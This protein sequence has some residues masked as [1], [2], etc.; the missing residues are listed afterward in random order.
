M[1]GEDCSCSHGEQAE[2]DEFTEKFEKEFSLM[3]CL[4]GSGCLVC[5]DIEAWFVDSGAS[6]HMTG[7]SSMFLSFS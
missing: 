1:E 3:T 6:F 7:M 4:S 2:F 5:E